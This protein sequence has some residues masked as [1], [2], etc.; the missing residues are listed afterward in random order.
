MEAQRLVI[1]TG[2]FIEFLRAKDKTKTHLYNLPDQGEIFISAVTLYELLMGATTQ[3][4]EKDVR[5]LT[6]DLIILPFS[7]EAAWEAS[8]IYHRLRKKNQMIEFRDIFIGATCLLNNLK[9][10][11]LNEKHFSRI[12]ELKIWN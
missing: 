5:L 1:D 2:I 4:K 6:E 7:K 11:T 9:I 8:K 3:E 12:K 10:F